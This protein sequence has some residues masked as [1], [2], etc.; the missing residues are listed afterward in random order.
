MIQSVDNL[1]TAMGNGRTYRTDWSKISPA[2][3]VAGRCYDTTAW[4][5]YPV[6]NAY[7]GTALNWVGCNEAAGNGTQIFG[8]PH[9]GNV[10]SL[11]KH[12]LSLSFQGFVATAVPATALI[13]D[14]QGYYTGLNM[15]LATAQTLVGSPS[16]RYASGAGVMAFLTARATLGSTAQTFSFNFRNQAGADVASSVTIGGNASAVA[17]TIIHSGVAANNY[18]PF[19][20]LPSG[21]TGIQYF[22]TFTASASGSASTAALVLA[23][24]L[25]SISIGILGLQSEKDL[26]NQIP[27]LPKVIDGACLGVILIAGA[28]LASASS[29]IGHVETV[30]G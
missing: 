2:V 17:G 9:G 24:P 6:A 26:L 12:I 28:A 23:K 11:I 30:W 10:S 13:V 18:G 29:L 16:L 3:S 14:I 5:G 21:S 7:P 20:P 1:I 19:L 8:L 27:S 22:N 25:A 4:A 15:N